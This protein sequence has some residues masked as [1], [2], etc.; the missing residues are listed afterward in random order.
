METWKAMAWAAGVLGVFGIVVST[1]DIPLTGPT[2]LFVLV[3]V[4]VASVVFYVISRYGYRLGHSIGEK[5][6]EDE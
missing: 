5:M 4:S 3:V 1:G 2:A 6:S